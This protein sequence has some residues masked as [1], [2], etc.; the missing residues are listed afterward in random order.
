MRML[1]QASASLNVPVSLMKACFSLPGMG[2]RIFE[3]SVRVVPPI[4]SDMGAER[5]TAHL[6]V[7]T[8]APRPGK[9]DSRTNSG[10]QCNSQGTC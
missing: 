1:V 10:R 5:G 2:S 6:A 3:F 9:P 7:P 8:A 4:K